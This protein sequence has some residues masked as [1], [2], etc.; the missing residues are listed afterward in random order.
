MNLDQDPALVDR[1]QEYKERLLLDATLRELVND[2]I[3]VSDEDIK[4]YFDAHR[5]ELPPIEEAHAAHIVVRTEREAKSILAQLRRGADFA[6]LAKT[7]SIDAGS[8][9]R[10]GDL[11]AIRKGTVI[12]EIELVVFQLK[13]GR[14]SDI[15]KTPNGFEIIR[16]KS[17]QVHR[18]NTADE[19]KSEIRKKIE[20]EKEAA[21]FEELVK[22]LK[23]ESK[24]AVTDATLGSMGENASSSLDPTAPDRH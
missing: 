4:T 24:I 22:T 19:V 21:L 18:P 15:V 16:V 3:N 1:V 10:G 7:H 12:P 23:A 14:T 2:K 13:P 17:R 8:K 6:A 5:E 11:G 20:T 9:D